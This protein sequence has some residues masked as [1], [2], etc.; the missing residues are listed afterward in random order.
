MS[1]LKQLRPLPLWTFSPSIILRASLLLGFGL[2][3]YPLA[4]LA[5]PAQAAIGSYQEDKTSNDYCLACHQEKGLTLPLG[6]DS[7]PITIN[8]TAFGLSVHA[9]EDVA[10]V[11]CHADIR[12]YPHPAVEEKSAREYALSFAESCK[13]CHEDQYEESPDSVHT[14]ALNEGDEN[15]PLCVSC[16]NPHTQGR[17][18]GQ[19]SG[20]LT[21]SARVHIPETCAQ[22]HIE[23]YDQYEDSVHGKALTEEGNRD[24]PTC[25]ECHGVHGGIVDPTTPLFRNTS[26]ALCADC[27]DD[28]EIMDKYD[29][30]T[31]VLE[32][33]VADFHGTNV[34]LFSEQF[35][36]GV[37]NKAVCFDCHGVHD[38]AK[39]NDP[40]RGITLR[41]N[42]LEKCQRCH[43][44]ATE[45]FPGAWL[46][47]TYASPTHHPIAYY[48]SLFYKIFIPAVIGG[49]VFFIL[50]D[51]Y[52]RRVNRSKGVK[53][54]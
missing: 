48:V 43:T 38:I 53:R 19:E 3:F 42:I 50:T 46:G 32:T 6:N 16:H 36:D 41:A 12:E 5:T 11:D 31:E 27:H 26:P 10:C 44:D 54:P 9:E 45:N 2:L 18:I 24:V 49:M 21:I 33:Y 1:R 4:V 17:L 22:C 13:E 52:R 29:I 23:K 40:V 28:P 34:K 20:E 14:K 35:P 39:V 15:A 51:I 37:T 7:L 47:H 25:T 30:S 8:P